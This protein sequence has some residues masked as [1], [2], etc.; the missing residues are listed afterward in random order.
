MLVANFGYNHRPNSALNYM[1]PLEVM[2]DENIKFTPTGRWILTLT[3]FSFSIQA[4]VYKS[5]S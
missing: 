3:D 5:K 2:I 4:Q 1:P